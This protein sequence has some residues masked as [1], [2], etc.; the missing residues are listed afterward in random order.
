MATCEPAIGKVRSL[1]RSEFDLREPST[2]GTRL[3]GLGCVINAA[4]RIDGDTYN[5][6]ATNAL[7]IGELAEHIN[8]LRLPK[9]IELSTGAVYGPRDE[10]THPALG[11][12][13]TGDYPVSK[14]LAERVLAERFG[15]RL[16][17][18]RL[19]CPWGRYQRSP[20]L[21]PR[22][23]RDI[24]AG[25]VLRCGRQGG[26]LLSLTH[27]DDIARVILRDFVAADRDDPIVNIASDEVVGIARVAEVLGE[28][29]GREPRLHREGDPGNVLSV[30]Y[31]GF[32]WR[33][34]HLDRQV[35]ETFL[36]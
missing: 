28:A 14:Y 23:A 35:V 4:V 7:H 36:E 3:Q 8:A 15:G 10:P 18:L 26:P 21:I 33:R 5:V 24:A 34:F 1:T 13:P 2:W 20:R 31:P 32:A 12:K 19:Y 22:L 29:L 9:W 16:N 30:P 11:C 6:F 17:V 27:V 25:R